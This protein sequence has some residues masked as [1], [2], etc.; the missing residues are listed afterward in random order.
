M[1]SKLR[2]VYPGTEVPSLLET[3]TIA[4]VRGGKPSPKFQ[5]RFTRLPFLYINSYSS[6]T[7]K[8]T[9][10]I[11]PRLESKGH[12]P[13]ADAPYFTPCMPKPIRL[14]PAS[15]SP[16]RQLLFSPVPRPQGRF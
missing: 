2:P 7:T 10:V 14:I 5:A 1:R 12:P 15:F 8:L 11:R 9:F 6:I 3:P 13:L 4:T 16:E